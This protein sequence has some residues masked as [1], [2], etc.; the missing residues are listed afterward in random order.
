MVFDTITDRRSK[1]GALEA[2]RDMAKKAGRPKTSTGAAP[3]VRVEADL[4]S[5]L[6]YMAAQRGI[7]VAKFTSDLIRP[8]VEREFAKVAPKLDKGDKT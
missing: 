4:K 2:V 6:N 1:V 8:V 5:M 3:T 7:A